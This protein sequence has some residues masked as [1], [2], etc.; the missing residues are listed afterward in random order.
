MD[1]DQFDFYKF[2]RNEWKR[3]AHL[4]TDLSY[5]YTYI[6]EVVTLGKKNVQGAERAITELYALCKEYPETK[7]AVK[8]WI[9]D[10]YELH[11][12]LDKSLEALNDPDCIGFYSLEKALNLKILLGLSMNGK[13]LF[14]FGKNLGLKPSSVT[15]NH[16]PEFY[17][18]AEQTL[19]EFKK[20]NGKE[21]LQYLKN[22][23]AYIL[24][25]EN[26]LFSGIIDN[27]Q[28]KISKINLHDNYYALDFISSN[29]L[30]I[31]YEIKNTF[32]KRKVQQK[33]MVVPKSLSLR[34][35]EAQIKEPF[36]NPDKASSSTSCP[37]NHLHLINHWEPFRKY[38]CTDCH[39]IFMC[40][41]EKDLALSFASHQIE[42]TWLHGICPKCRGIDDTSMVT[43]GKLMYGSGTPFY[44]QH[45]REIYFEWISLKIN[46]NGVED[47]I[48][49]EDI[50]RTR[51]GL[52][53]IGEGWISETLL[54]KTIVKIFPNHKVI[55]HGKEPWLEKMH[56]DVYIPNLKLAFEYQGRQHYE[57]ID[58]FGGEKSFQGNQQRDKRKAELCKT[59]DVTLFY[60]KEG[61]DFS[62]RTIRKILKNYLNN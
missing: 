21:F 20:Q 43:D 37:H 11:G 39:S 61:E 45:W 18:I 1:K 58:Y 8:G 28:S 31:D 34:I 2:W 15:L 55:H 48:R 54:Y 35:W 40:D 50:V 30:K 36:D 25:S 24:S 26:Y 12:L 46:K 6:Y 32:S 60:I 3:G 59:N 14:I 41:C 51:Y 52:P 16:L 29:F 47:D 38:E 57:P 5:V 53:L 42:G 56:L 17:I 23:N 4:P 33:P 9:A 22:S 10:L 49:P 62:E 7:Y 27:V 19:K 13:E 44:A